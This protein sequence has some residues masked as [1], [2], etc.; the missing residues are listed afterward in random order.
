[1]PFAINF[2]EIFIFVNKPF[3][4]FSDQIMNILQ[5]VYISLRIYTYNNKRD[6]RKLY[7]IYESYE[8]FFIMFIIT[9]SWKPMI[10]HCAL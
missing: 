9:K 5:F 1:M 7:N 8:R 6:N 3:K 2:E 4:Y 10:E